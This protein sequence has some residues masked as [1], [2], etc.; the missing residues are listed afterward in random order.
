MKRIHHL[1]LYIL[2]TQYPETWQDP[3]RWDVM[4]EAAYTLL[5]G[6]LGI[7]CNP[8][9]R[10]PKEHPLIYPPRWTQ[11]NFRLENN[12]TPDSLQGIIFGTDPISKD[13][14]LS[15]AGTGYAF[16]FDYQSGMTNFAPSPTQGLLEAY[17]L[18]RAK[19]Y[20]INSRHLEQDLMQHGIGMVNFIRTIKQGS[21][22]GSANAFLKPWIA[23]NNAWLTFMQKKWE[24]TD[25]RERSDPS[26]SGCID[27]G[28]VLIFQN[29]HYPFDKFVATENDPNSDDFNAVKELLQKVP[30]CSHPS[31]IRA[32]VD[33]CLVKP[34]TFYKWYPRYGL[35][36]GSIDADRCNKSVIKFVAFLHRRGAQTAYHCQCIIHRDEVQEELF[37]DVQA[38][39]HRDSERP[40]DLNQTG[41]T[42]TLSISDVSSSADASTA[43]QHL[44]TTSTD[45]EANEV[46]FI[47]GQCATDLSSEDVDFDKSFDGPY[48][49]DTSTDTSTDEV[50]NAEPSFTNPQH[51]RD[52]P[53]T[54][55]H[56]QDQDEDDP[57][58]AALSDELREGA[59]IGG[60]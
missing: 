21:R 17:C 39:I 1:A 33:H 37:K 42:T 59:K 38:M 3:E 22:S 14:D 19:D 2:L 27:S 43:E 18:K 30:R 51:S 32:N 35:N 26:D 4:F 13:G 46:S 36:L 15:K 53:T 55:D 11:E 58:I 60:H 44:T 41:N 54:V 56:S 29:E 23:Y 8:G 50:S 10:P 16:T 20:A 25:R 12:L 31:Y 52:A 48:P 6:L 34:S 45:E 57:E 28:R 7:I 24:S 9:G 40:D 47:A 5:V 49:T